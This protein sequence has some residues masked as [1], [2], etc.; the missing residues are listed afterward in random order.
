MAT[1]GTIAF[2]NEDGSIDVVY[3][4]WDNYLASNGALLVQNY[5]TPEKV[6]QLLALGDISSLGSYVAEP[7]VNPSFTRKSDLGDYTV[8]YAYRGE[9]V[10][11]NRWGSFDDYERNQQFE[12]YNYLFTKD[13]VW[14]VF[15]EHERDWFDVEHELDKY[16]KSKAN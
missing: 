12:E 11:V 4:H 9:E 13:N 7:G 8:Y 16:A 14:S 5:N 1:R 3:S 6:K 10:R 2:E 15:I